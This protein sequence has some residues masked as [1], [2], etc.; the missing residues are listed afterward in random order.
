MYR[1]DTCLEMLKTQSQDICFKQMTVSQ[2]QPSNHR[3][4]VDKATL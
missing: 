4:L 1:Q 2:L 3:Q